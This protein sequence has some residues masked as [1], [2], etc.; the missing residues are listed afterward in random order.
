MK[1]QGEKH[2]RLVQFEPDIVGKSLNSRIDV[3]KD[4]FLLLGVVRDGCF[5]ARLLDQRMLQINDMAAAKREIETVVRSKENEGHKI[6]EAAAEI[7]SQP[8]YAETQSA[9]SNRDFY[10]AHAPAAEALLFSNLPWLEANVGDKY[11]VPG[12]EDKPKRTIFLKTTS[13]PTEVSFPESKLGRKKLAP[14]DAVRVKCEFDDNQ[15]IKIFVLENRDS[16]SSWDVFPE[17]IGIVDHV[18]HEKR[19]LHFIVA[20]DIDGVVPLSDLSDSAENLERIRR[21]LAS[22]LL[23]GIFGGTANMTVGLARSILREEAARTHLF[24]S[25]QLV[26]Q[27][28]K[29]GRIADFD[30]EA[31]KKYLSMDYRKTLGFVALSLIYDKHDWLNDRTQKDYVFPSEFFD[32]LRLISLDIPV[33]ELEAALDSWDRIANMLLLSPDEHIEKSELGFN[34]W[35][36]TRE[37]EFLDYH[38]LPRDRELY[39]PKNFIRF[40]RSREALIT[41]RL[42]SFFEFGEVASLGKPTEELVPA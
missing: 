23:N 30:D 35:A 16:E 33:H 42:K 32:E 41:A 27:M 31:I 3:G 40:I 11:T 21:W 6:P 17:T 20:R 5:L 25:K 24:P 19:V 1:I 2:F 14:G 37:D 36:L 34:E 7:A 28:T 29:R 4:V 12:K 13:V 38:L 8:W 10:H 15:R 9:A 26:S 22:A 18:N 39:L